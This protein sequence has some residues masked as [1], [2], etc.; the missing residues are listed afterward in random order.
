MRRFMSSFVMGGTLAVIFAA[1]QAPQT[2]VADVER[3]LD[4]ARPKYRTAFNTK[5]VPSLVAFYASEAIFLP[6]HGGPVSGRTNIEG[7]FKEM[8]N[9]GSNLS[10]ASTRVD[11]SGDLAYE[12]GNY[13]MTF[14][15]PGMPAVADTG[16][17]VVVFKRQP[18]GKWLMVAHTSNTNLPPPMPPPAET[19][20][21]K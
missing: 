18:D 5:D 20:K 6:T 12:V 3:Y 9:A 13:T 14:Q 2:N 15:M 7:M 1:C 19:I 4:E 8:V 17:Y 21:K 11:A 10:I 16:K